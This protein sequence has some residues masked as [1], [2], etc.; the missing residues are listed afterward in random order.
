MSIKINREVVCQDG[1]RMSVQA[2]G[3]TYCTPRTTDAPAYTAV[4][5][6]YPNREEPLLMDWCEDSNWPMDTVY[7][8]VPASV[9]ATVCAKHGGIVSGE[10]PP[11]I[12][13][14][15]SKEGAE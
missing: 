9:I 4:E 13:Y 10:L 1:F 15:K 3:G 12:P 6:G 5:V 7:A 2:N 14:L 8:Y 11:G